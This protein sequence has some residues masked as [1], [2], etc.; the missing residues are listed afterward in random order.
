MYAFLDQ[1]KSIQNL[2]LYT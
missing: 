1:N 2:G